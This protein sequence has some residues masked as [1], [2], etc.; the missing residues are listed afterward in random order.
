MTTDASS[1][2]AL[3][4]R[5]ASERGVT[6]LETVCALF[7]FALS[8]GTMSNFIV[9]QIRSSNTNDNY[10]LAYELAVQELEDFR[11]Q[12]YDQMESRSREHQVGGM[13]FEIE[14]SVEEGVPSANMKTIDVGIHWNEPAGARNVALQTIY[15][16]VTR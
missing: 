6:L 10:T 12:L 9:T 2:G 1:R 4:R 3:R 11:A 5:L 7:L 8:I 16:A 14:T 13:T 15:T